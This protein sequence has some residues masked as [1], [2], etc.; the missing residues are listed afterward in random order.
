MN[1]REI[2][3]RYNEFVEQDRREEGIKFLD[4]Y[5]KNAGGNVSAKVLSYAGEDIL[6]YTDELAKGIEYFH[7]A[8]KKE[9]DNPDIY[10][11]YFTNLDEITD[12]YPETIDDAVL[13]LTKVIE[14]V[15]KIKIK[16]TADNEE[17]KQYDY[18]E[19]MEDESDKERDIARR[20]RD[21]AVIYM[22]IP[23]YKKAKE[24]ITK[25]LKVLP[26]DNL[27]NSLKAEI[28]A[29]GGKAPEAKEKSREGSIGT[30]RALKRISVKVLLA[31]VAII[32]VKSALIGVFIAIAMA[33]MGE[34]KS[35]AI[36]FGLFFTPFFIFL[37]IGMDAAT[38]NA[39]AGRIAKKTMEKNSKKENFGRC[40]T[41]ITEGSFT[42]GA[43]LTIDEN[44][45]RVAY[46][47]YWNPHEFQMMHAKD[48]TN[49]KSS[50]IKA[51]FG[52]TQYVYFEFYYKNKRVRIPTFTASKVVYSLQSRE[53]LEGISKAD[54]FCDL[55]MNAQN[56]GA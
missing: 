21:L 38:G 12:E 55:L 3:D 27:A 26:D 48:L 36:E 9:P 5:V 30:T 56:V 20:Y 52:G 50:Y 44:T 40:S 39:R 32:C 22:K 28:D 53:V 13:C 25:T 14:I 33:A 23:D 42:I 6:T 47:S 10:W 54:T 17:E 4:E 43:I 11:S 46:V 35:M 51:P 24:C 37:L 8:M 41:F 19:D 29:A 31:Q 16:N 7:R 45:G 18:I 49:I 15:S 2:L 1:G 34:E